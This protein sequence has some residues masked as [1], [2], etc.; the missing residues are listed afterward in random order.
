MLKVMRG[1]KEALDVVCTKRRRV[2]EVHA[3]VDRK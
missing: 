2:L 3:K 1:L